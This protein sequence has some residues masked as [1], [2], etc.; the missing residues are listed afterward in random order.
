MHRLI[1]TISLW[2]RLS[3]FLSMIPVSIEFL[4]IQSVFSS[5]FVVLLV[6]MGGVASWS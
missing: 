4:G 1:G 2:C 6:I 3:I 5:Y